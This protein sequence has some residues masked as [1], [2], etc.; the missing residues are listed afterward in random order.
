MSHG[1]SSGDPKALL[2]ASD[3]ELMALL[4][5]QALPLV[6]NPSEVLAMG[7]GG[8]LYGNP[9]QLGS[10]EF[11]HGALAAVGKTF[12]HKWA[13]QL[14]KAICT[15]SE[16]Y[17]KLRQTGSAQTDLLVAVSVGG[18]AAAI[19]ALAPFSGLLTVVGVLLAKTGVDAFCEMLSDKNSPLLK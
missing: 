13:G 16:L 18:L 7:R 14:Q 17:K 15:K 12:L 2:Q 10:G 1:I 9:E 3:S 4:G 8:E 11:E 19:P 5:L 6:K